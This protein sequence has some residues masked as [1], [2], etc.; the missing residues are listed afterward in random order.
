MPYFAWKKENI[1]KGLPL[2]NGSKK[3]VC[4]FDEETF[5][6]L[7]ELAE[8]EKTSFAEAVRIAVALG[9]EELAS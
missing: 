7:V 3:C 2:K 1:A 9:L 5:E 6:D 8:K 4:I